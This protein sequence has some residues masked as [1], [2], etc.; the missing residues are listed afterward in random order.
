MR[1][2]YVRTYV[3]TYAQV[4]S[5]HC[6]HRGLQLR[7]CNPIL[8]IVPYKCTVLPYLRRDGV[9]GVL[10]HDD[11]ERQYDR[12]HLLVHG[13]LEVESDLELGTTAWTTWTTW[14]TMGGGV[15]WGRG[16]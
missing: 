7:C 3:R 15:G 14:T 1:T 12:D 13:L 5:T 10:A 4:R 9:E 16:K 11:E 8:K 6:T 2:T